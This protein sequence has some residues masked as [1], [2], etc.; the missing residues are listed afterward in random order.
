MS[1]MSRPIGPA[2]LSMS[3]PSIVLPFISNSS[4]TGAMWRSTKSATVAAIMRWFS[5][6]SSGVKHAAGAVSRRMNSP[7]VG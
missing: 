5:S 3:R 2:A 7:P 1:A 6:K 4:R